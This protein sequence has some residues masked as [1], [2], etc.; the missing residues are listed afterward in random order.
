MSLWSRIANLIRS[1]SLSRQIDEELHSQVDT[2]TMVHVGTFETQRESDGHT[3]F[4]MICYTAEHSG[5]LSYAL[6]HVLGQTRPGIGRGECSLGG[7][8]RFVHRERA[9]VPEQVVLAAVPAIQAAH[10]DAGDSRDVRDR[11]VRPFAGD[12]GAGGFEHEPVIPLGLGLAASG[13][14]RHGGDSTGAIRSVM[15]YG[16]RSE[17]L[18]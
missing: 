11:R 4:R 10:P 5:P 8:D 16:R 15:M 1:D 7:L 18:R 6:G 9:H 13:P 2:A 17:P 12:D 14:G 3:E